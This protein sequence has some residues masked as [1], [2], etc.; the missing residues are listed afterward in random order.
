M[1]IEM[2]TQAPVA[3]QPDYQ[4]LARNNI[5]AE[6]SKLMAALLLKNGLSPET[7][8][9]TLEGI[10]R[11]FQAGVGGY[12]N[13]KAQQDDFA[14]QNAL[15]NA[16]KGQDVDPVAMAGIAAGYDGAFNSMMQ[17]R[18]A[19]RNHKWTEAHDA[20]VTKQNH[21]WTAAENDKRD[22]ASMARTKLQADQDK[23]E[24]DKRYE[25]VMGKI[26]QAGQPK[27]QVY[28]RTD[29]DKI[30]KV[31]AMA[32][33]A[34]AAADMFRDEFAGFK[35][36]GGGAV[37]AG[38]YLGGKYQPMAQFWGDYATYRNAIRHELFGS[39]LTVGEAAA[40]AQSDVTY[41]DDPKYVRDRLKLNGLLALEGK[42]KQAEMAKAQ[43]HSDE[44]IRAAYGISPEKLH[45]PVDWRGQYRKVLA[46]DAGNDPAKIAAANEKIALI[47]SPDSDRL[48]SEVAGEKMQ[49]DPSGAAPAG[50]PPSEAQTGAPAPA[51]EPAGQPAPEQAAQQAPAPAGQPP[52]QPAAQL[53]PMTPNEIAGAK[54][55]LINGVDRNAIIEHLRGSG[56][57]PSGF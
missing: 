12:L 21:E 5:G 20:E 34:I 11:V 19:Q 6:H 7:P 44:E 56:V 28:N 49:G 13:N 32:D 39:A 16:L 53:R 57:D 14:K 30:G 10:S 3:A 4:A 54:K 48:Y 26:G 51:T 1:P 35:G 46:M 43:G 45:V 29:S 15:I 8:K 36:A 23:Y 33:K 2:T 17:D 41:D 42:R 18:V 38:R 31:T 50:Q 9:S 22:A 40:F 37:M 55:A 47:S 25:A 27:L 24:A 52:A